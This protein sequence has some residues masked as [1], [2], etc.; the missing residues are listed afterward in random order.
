MGGSTDKEPAVGLQRESTCQVS[1]ERSLRLPLP[2]DKLLSVVSK[3]KW[4]S[5]SHFHHRVS[6]ISRCAGLQGR[7]WLGGVL[8]PAWLL[9][10]PSPAMV[11]AP[12]RRMPHTPLCT[13]LHG[14]EGSGTSNET[15]SPDVLCGLFRARHHHSPCWGK[16]VKRECSKQEMI[17]QFSAHISG[18]ICAT[19]NTPLHFALESA[20]KINSKVTPFCVFTFEDIQMCILDCPDIA[21]IELFTATQRLILH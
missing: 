17:H 4:A 15:R 8:I 1:E 5:S 9:P 18:N 19:T 12:A 6:A 14:Q 13:A 7:A 10:L 16:A 3:R 21:W 20:Y 11:P 2:P